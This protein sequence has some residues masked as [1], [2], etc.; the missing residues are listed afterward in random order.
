MYRAEDE[1]LNCATWTQIR[2]VTSCSAQIRY[3]F[4]QTKINQLLLPLFNHSFQAV[5]V[6]FHSA[7]CAMCSV[8]AQAL[9]MA[10]HL[11]HGLQTHLDFV[12][13]DGDRNDLPWHYTIDQ[14]P[15][16]IAFPPANSTTDSR[17]FPTTAAA[18]VPNVLAF[19]LANLRRPQ[20]L[21]ALLLVCHHVRVSFFNMV[22]QYIINLNI[23][24]P[25]RRLF[26][27]ITT[28]GQRQHRFESAPM[29]IG[30]P[31]PQRHPA[32][33]ASTAATLPATPLLRHDQ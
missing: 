3:F 1:T 16:L 13:I 15:T 7:Q 4:Q 31:S 23:P 33:T 10:A 19:V 6:L 22:F 25:R 30:S 5:F 8:L 29:A 26:A 28:R 18:T 17:I 24:E 32:Q 12:R 21:H 11:L 20:R 9:L 14:Y 27:H 2:S